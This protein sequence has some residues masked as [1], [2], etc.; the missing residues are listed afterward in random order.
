MI[1]TRSRAATVALVEV[2]SC[3]DRNA[4]RG[5]ESRRDGAEARSWILF[6]VGFRIAFDRE[7]RLEESLVAPRDVGAHGD[8]F[9]ARHLADSSDDFSV[10]PRDLFRLPGIR[11]DR[12]VDR[13]HVV[14][15]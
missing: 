13:Q 5:E 14:V 15:Y 6:A 10:E 8:A 12:H 4:E 2:T 7:L 1:T 11:D 9:H 3:D